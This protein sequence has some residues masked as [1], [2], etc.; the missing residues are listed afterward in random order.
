MTKKRGMAER[1][2]RRGDREAI[3]ERPNTVQHNFEY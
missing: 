3:E 2:M 1:E